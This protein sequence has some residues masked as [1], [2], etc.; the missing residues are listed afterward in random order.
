MAYNIANNLRISTPD[1]IG[2]DQLKRKNA[3]ADMQMQQEQQRNA[4]YGRQI[5]Q[6]D[7]RMK[8]D[9][10]AAALER[11][12]Q[13]A[14]GAIAQVEQD[15]S[16]LPQFLA[17]GQRLGIFDPART[18]DS[19]TPKDIADL[20]VEL[21]I[22]PPAA[23]VPFEQT[24]EGQKLKM[25]GDQAMALARFNKAADA[26]LERLRQSAPEKAKGASW[27]KVEKPLPDGRIQI[28]FI[29]KNS[30]TPDA[31]F[32]PFGAP[33]QRPEAAQ[34]TASQQAVEQTYELYK[35]AKQGL[36]DGLEGSVTGPVMGR[37][38]AVTAEQQIAE[39][40]VAAMAPVLKQLFRVAGEG[41][42]TDKDQELLL[43]M[44]PTR[45]TQ[46]RAREAQIKNIDN[47]VRAKLGI[48]PDAGDVPPDI[49]A[50]LQ[51]HGGK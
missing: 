25:Q 18:P 19:V 42:F 31:T 36:L 14:P 32:R 29:D 22:A 43:K 1:P 46:P 26:A 4:L 23:P 3:L 11:V 21:G 37:V 2:V 5:A 20:K 35:T 13:W 41:V 15:P 48:P 40:G 27:D 47:I 17:T 51:K 44:I 6:N 49:A 24:P 39:G 10:Q 9:E 16:L 33:T 28:G 8:A 50:I 12:R 45:A 30:P 38:P 34:K 7:S